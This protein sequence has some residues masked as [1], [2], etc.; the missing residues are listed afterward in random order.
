MF[1]ASWPLRRMVDSAR[2]VAR[3]RGIS[4]SVSFGETKSYCE[5]GGGERGNEGKNEE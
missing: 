5:R 2:V 1:L 3:E 4:D